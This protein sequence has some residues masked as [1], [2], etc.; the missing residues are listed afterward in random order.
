MRPIHSLRESLSS[1]VA[2]GFYLNLMQS[3]VSKRSRA[4][5]IEKVQADGRKEVRIGMLGY[6]FMGK[7]HTNAYKKIPYIYPDANIMPRLL[8]LCGRNEENV[9]REAARYG[10]EEYCTDWNELV[11]DDRIDVF[12]NCGSDHVHAEPC[13]AALK[14]GKNII[15]E[16]PLALSVEDAKRMRDESSVAVGKAMCVFNY[17]FIPRNIIKFF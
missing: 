4:M 5:A 10:Y 16:K 7:C 6:G 15:C 1:S 17:R 11:N 8:V 9:K 2:G 12:A 3:V 14:N 13:M